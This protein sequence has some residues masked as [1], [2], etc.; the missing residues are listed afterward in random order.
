MS[1]NQYDQTIWAASV[2]Y[3]VPVP[4]IKAVIMTESSF[5]PKAYRAEPAISDGSYGLMQVLFRTAVALGF[6]NDPAQHERLF[7]V[8]TNIDLGTKLLKQLIGRYGMNPPDLYAAYNAGSVRKNAAGQYTNSKGDTGVQLRVN[9]FMG[10]YATF[11]A[12]W[13]KTSDPSDAAVAPTETTPGAGEVDSGM[14]ISLLLVIA[15][16]YF[17]YKTWG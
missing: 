4:L 5:N 17:A 13:E 3:D 2:G 7:D 1:Y 9:R 14:A 15:L 11:L 12:E 10:I 8:D 16:G 6:P